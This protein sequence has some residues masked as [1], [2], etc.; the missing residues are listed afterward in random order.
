MIWPYIAFALAVFVVLAG[1]VAIWGWK[2]VE[3]E[4]DEVFDIAFDDLR[5]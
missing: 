4:L 2:R 3:D 1:A 5:F